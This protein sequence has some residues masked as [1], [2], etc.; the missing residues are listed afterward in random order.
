VFPYPQ[1]TPACAA[2]SSIDEQV[3][4][5]VTL[6]FMTPIFAIGLWVAQ[7]LW[8]SVPETAIHK[9]GEPVLAENKIRASQQGQMSAPA[10]DP[11]PPENFNQAHFGGLVAFGP[12]RRHDLRPL[13]FADGI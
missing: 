3:P 5:P 8:A 6:D 9:N 2:Q 10:F 7:M 11:M 13:L 1:N 4:P 12:H